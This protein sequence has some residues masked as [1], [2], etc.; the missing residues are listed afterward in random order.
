ML[1]VIPCIV[2]AMVTALMF[3]LFFPVEGI[4]FTS[5]IFLFAMGCIAFALVNLGLALISYL[6]IIM[7]SWR[8]Q[9][10]IAAAVLGVIGVITFQVGRLL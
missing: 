9:F 7:T 4:N 6:F 2:L 3:K 5:C 1:L 8:R 10:L